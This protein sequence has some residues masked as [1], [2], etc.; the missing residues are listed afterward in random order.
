MPNLITSFLLLSAVSFLFS[1]N[2]NEGKDEK[3][4]LG[5]VVD[6][7]AWASSSHVFFFSR[8]DLFR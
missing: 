1:F 2:E 5:V 8:L 7:V 6:A 4:R 3:I